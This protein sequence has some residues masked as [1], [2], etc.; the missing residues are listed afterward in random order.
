MIF[1]L[2]GVA[3]FSI[4]VGDV[5][6]DAEGVVTDAGDVVTDAG[7]VVTDAEDIFIIAKTMA[8]FLNFN[9]NLPILS[10]LAPHSLQW[11]PNP[12]INTF[13]LAAYSQNKFQLSFFCHLFLIIFVA[14]QSSFEEL[15][16]SSFLS[17]G[18]WFIY[19]VFSKALF[20]QLVKTKFPGELF[21][22][23]TRSFPPHHQK[24]NLWILYQGSLLLW[25]F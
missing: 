5:V 18:L 15:S 25:I 2:V 13:F 3:N 20:Y 9:G 10:H 16:S 24:S 19:W 6:A 23:F 1:W 22:Q 7:D 17:Y 8:P 21:S 14:E 4:D 12:N 11:F